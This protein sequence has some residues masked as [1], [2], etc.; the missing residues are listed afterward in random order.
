MCP[1]C[2]EIFKM[3]SDALIPTHDFPKPCR[4]VCPGSGQY[5]RNPKTD[6]RPLWKDEEKEESEILQDNI[7]ILRNW[8]IG[9]PVEEVRAEAAKAGWTCRVR[10][11][12]GKSMIGT[13]DFVT[14]RFNV[15]V[16]N[17]LIVSVDGI[18]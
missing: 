18:G 10:N 3:R 2:G 15:T 1:H 17:G 5:P 6:R 13:C 11:A 16:E 4:S 7:A 14:N 9:N 8:A 12:D